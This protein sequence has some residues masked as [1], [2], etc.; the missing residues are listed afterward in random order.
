[1]ALLICTRAEIE[2]DL[3]ELGASMVVTPSELKGAMATWEHSPP[4]LA[5]D[6]IGGDAAAEMAKTLE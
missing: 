4:K 6:C 1:M 5:L 2:Q 3:K